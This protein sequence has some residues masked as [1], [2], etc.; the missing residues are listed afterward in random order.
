VTTVSAQVPPA[1][2]LQLEEAAV[3]RGSS[4]SEEI[5]RRLDRSFLVEP[6]MERNQRL[7]DLQMQGSVKLVESLS[8]EVRELRSALLPTFAKWL[9][10]Q[11]L[12]TL[13]P[14]F[15]KWLEAQQSA[16]LESSAGHR[17][18]TTEGKPLNL[19]EKAA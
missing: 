4:L 13:M 19:Q 17:Q 10:T 18:D 9:E 14:T 7:A 8:Q 2:K 15:A 11:Q 3:N 12:A 16:T 5:R 6:L 1:L